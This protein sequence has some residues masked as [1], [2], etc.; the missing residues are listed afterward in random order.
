MSS[1]LDK[2]STGELRALAKFAN[3]AGGGGGE[4]QRGRP[5]ESEQQTR[6]RSHSVDASAF[7]CRKCGGEFVDF[8]QLRPHQFSCKKEPATEEDKVNAQ[9]AT[10]HF[11]RRTQ[12]KAAKA[13]AEKAAAESVSEPVVATE[14]VAKATGKTGAKSAKKVAADTVVSAPAHCLSNYKCLKCKNGFEFALDALACMK[15]HSLSDGDV[16]QLTEQLSTAEVKV[17][18]FTSTLTG[19]NGDMAELQRQMEVLSHTIDCAKLNLAA[20]NEKVAKLKKQ[21]GR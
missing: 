11:K 17:V 5:T 9:A 18:S 6:H 1:I 8:K 2:M 19:L 12:R 7:H 13:A 14:P 10:I 21:L 16:S 3:S 20:E 4:Q 15:S